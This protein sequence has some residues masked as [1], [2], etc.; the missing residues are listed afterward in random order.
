ML[1][2]DGLATGSCLSVAVP[3]LTADIPSPIDSL[4]IG[5]FPIPRLSHSEPSTSYSNRGK[6]FRIDLLTPSGQ[7]NT[8]PIFI[9]RLNALATPLKYMDYLIEDPVLAALIAGTP[10]LVKV[11]QPARYALH[12]LI[13]SRERANTSA[14]KKK[15]DLI[16]AAN[17][18]AILKEDHPGALQI[19]MDA[20][21]AKGVEWRR[22]VEAAAKE[23][24]IEI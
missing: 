15:M 18:I 7:G 16:Q 10:C 8:A 13:I 24:L 4:K 9:R 1:Q 20:L 3:N 12:K 11:P 22:K 2:E 19:A 17:L 6:T 14:D 5:Y 23:G 21:V